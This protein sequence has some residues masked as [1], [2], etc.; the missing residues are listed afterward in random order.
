MHAHD[1][2]VPEHGSVTSS[3]SC[4]LSTFFTM[5]NP[6]SLYFATS[7]AV[8]GC[9]AVELD[10]QREAVGRPRRRRAT[11]DPGEVVEI[12]LRRARNRA[13]AMSIDAYQA[14]GIERATVAL[15][16]TRQSGVRESVHVHALSH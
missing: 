14:G 7:C 2:V 4:G 12:W 1:G 16:R 5:R 15:T 3:T 13:A 11:D 9:H 8:G 6:S 10:R